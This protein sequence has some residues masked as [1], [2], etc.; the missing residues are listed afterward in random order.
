[1]IKAAFLSQE[2]I[3]AQ[4]YGAGRRERLA[5][6]ADLFPAVITP[7]DLNEN[8]PLLHDI[9]AL[10]SGWG[11]P[12]LTDPQLDALPNLKIVFY[13]A[14]S[15]QGFARPLLARGIC[16]VSAWRANAVPVAEFTLAQILLSCKGYFRNIQ[17]HSGV[18]GTF[19]S[20][21]RGPG[22]YGEII[23]LLGVGAIGGALIDMLRPFSLRVLVYDPI[24]G[25]A[26]RDSGAESV[27]LKEAFERAFVVS[28]H[29]ADK[30]ET[31]N[32]L[33]GALF[34]RMRPGA[35]FINTG[36]GRTVAEG[37]LCDV[38]R[39]RSDL[40]ALLDVTAP[41]PA[42]PDS[43]L[44]TLPN[45]HVSTHIAGSI[46]DE[47]LRLSDCCLAEFDRYRHGLP[48]LHEIT[49]EMLDLLA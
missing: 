22:N 43:P 42:A 33:N 39:R 23:A 2:K 4:V 9:E 37:E 25:N 13:A 38:L 34:E 20:A 16:V 49:S 36:R 47:V 15:V 8:P 12:C 40:T 24:T 17:E 1:M 29:L 7:D 31:R 30:T 10:F 19:S 14:G 46:N 41:E 45:V 28:N 48:L 32:L 35:T 3:I 11:M 27:A 21:T 5:A 44:F 6:C 18:S 26:G